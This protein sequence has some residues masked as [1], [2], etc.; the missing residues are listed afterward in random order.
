MKSLHEA[1]FAVCEKEKDRV[2]YKLQLEEGG[3]RSVTYKEFVSL[4]KKLTTHLRKNGVSPGGKVLMASE[5]CPEWTMA[6]M[7]VSNIGATLVPI[8]SITSA[9]EF[10]NIIDRANPQFC[11]LSRNCP[12]YT[13]ISKELASRKVGILD[14]NSQDRE[15]LSK[16]VQL[17]EA[18]VLT[19][20]NP[21]DT[22]LLIFT[23]G[24]TG[25]PKGVPISHENILTN[26]QDVLK[27]VDASSSDRIV[28]VLPLSHMLEFT[29]GFVVATLARAQVTYVKSLKAEDLLMALKDSKATT[30]IGV[31]LLFEVIARSLQAKLD[32]LPKSLGSAIQLLQSTDLGKK[33]VGFPIKKALGGNIR[34]FI[35]GGSKLQPATYVFFE[36]LG[37]PILQGYGLTE[38]SPVLSITN[39]QTAGP[40]HVGAALPSVE[41]S[42]RG[43]SD[44]IL[45]QGE[46]GEIW[47]R[48]S[49]VF[50]GYLDA[51]HTQTA[52]FEDWFRT[53]DLGTL[54][55]KG[56]LRI[57][58]RKKDIIVSSAGKNIYPEEIEALI[59][60]TNQFLEATIIGVADQQGH[61]NVVLV[62]VPDRTKFKG[63]SNEEITR[64]CSVLVREI[65][66]VL[67]DYKRPK[68]IEIWFDE[69]PKT[70]TR[71]VKKHEVKK[72]LQQKNQNLSQQKNTKEL[73]QLNSKLERIVA[74]AISHISH[75]PAD[76]IG[77]ND[78]LQRDFG[79]DSLTLIELLSSVEKEFNIK[80][81][82]L[83]FSQIQTVKDFLTVLQFAVES[84]PKFRFFKNV[85]FS[86]FRPIDNL[87]FLWSIPRKLIQFFLKR[88]IRQ[89]HQLRVYGLENISDKSAFVFCPNHTSH[90]D[91]L[92]ITSALPASHVK[93]TFAVAAKDY[94]FRTAMTSLFARLTVNA[95]PFDRKGR[96]LESM[97]LCQSALSDGRH[98]VIFPEGT[99]SVDGSLQ[100]F[101]SGVG[102]LLAGE[103]CLAVPVYIRGA[104]K[105]MP[106]G[107]RWPGQGHLEVFFGEPV[108]FA[109][110]AKDNESY[111]EIAK[112]IQSKVEDLIRNN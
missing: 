24:T 63:M 12:S 30:L 62:A 22:S 72:L 17:S 41:L 84:K 29:G 26:A 106:K 46:E 38:T 66:Q 58:G 2:A 13:E 97:Q 40:D 64:E 69:L 55:N 67:S 96:I 105:I 27:V 100:E 70:M 109:S 76:E 108:S 94:F 86:E 103:K 7:A 39:L 60:A 45:K 73:L 1:I 83:D 104:H 101:K 111:K 112:T 80:V 44:E 53:G 25:S 31:P 87:F 33:I 11:F 81:E 51:E 3:Y 8:A 74:E 57:T 49:S 14:W 90:F 85:P 77:I 98:L 95:I 21:K 42:I 79:L 36:K 75:T 15:P 102:Q 43:S 4:S 107:S 110:M 28:S 32:S 47:A 61:E 93:N 5:N 89:K 16:V 10:R 34:F 20:L 68:K 88:Y 59:L 65:C 82:G 56:M 92:S 6:A 52:F 23:S 37:I 78:S 99:R 35:A 50:S 71:K 91:L 9:L 19:G 48:G 54:D 18:D